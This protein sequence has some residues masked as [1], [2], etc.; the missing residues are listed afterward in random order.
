LASADHR[1]WHT[2]SIRRLDSGK[3]RVSLKSILI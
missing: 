1:R 2:V 3:K